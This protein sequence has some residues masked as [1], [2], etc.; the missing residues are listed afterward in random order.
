VRQARKPNWNRVIADLREGVAAGNAPAMTE[1]AITIN[2]GIRDAYGRILVRRNAPYAFRLLRRAV[3]SGD[4]NAAG[5]L[6]YAYNVGKGTKRNVAQAIRW[7]RRAARSGDSTERPTWRRYI[8]TPAKPGSRFNGG[9]E[10]PTCATEMP[11][12]MLATVI[13]TA[14]A[15]ERTPRTRSA[16]S[17]A[18]LSPKTFPNMA[19]KRRCITLPFS[20]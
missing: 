19:A 20:S 14:L 16:C 13:N 2:D 18:R 12:S 6:G 3:E 1:L 9:H 8:A 4:E 7:Y 11:P 17:D 5:S 10:P 15:H